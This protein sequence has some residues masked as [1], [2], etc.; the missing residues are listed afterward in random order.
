MVAFVALYSTSLGEREMSS[1]FLIIQYMHAKP[2]EKHN[3]LVDLLSSLL[4]DQSKSMKPHKE[5]SQ[6]EA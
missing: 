1:H 2:N 6:A 4:L 5:M 3:T